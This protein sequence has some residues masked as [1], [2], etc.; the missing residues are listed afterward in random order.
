M[1]TRFGQPQPSDPTTE[2]FTVAYTILLS[3]AHAAKLHRNEH[4][5]KYGG[6]IAKHAL[7]QLLRAV[8]RRRPP[9]TSK[10]PKALANSIGWFADPVYLSGEYPA[11]MRAQL[12]DRLP[13]FTDAGKALV[14]RSSDFCGMNTYTTFSSDT[15]TRRRLWTITMATLEKL[16]V[17]KQGVSREPENDT[18]WLGTCP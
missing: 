1:L 12:G 7:G 18:E 16:T 5:T 3:H 17:N 11:C 15:G 13:R 8:G 10:P 14:L 6:T 9:W 4:V 2:P